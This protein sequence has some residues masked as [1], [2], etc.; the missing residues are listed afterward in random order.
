MPAGRPK[1]SKNNPGHSAGGKC[2]GSGPKKQ[3]T[4]GPSEK[5]LRKRKGGCDTV[6][7]VKSHAH[8]FI[9]RNDADNNDPSPSRRGVPPSSPRLEESGAAD[10]SS[11]GQTTVR[12]IEPPKIHSIFG[13]SNAIRVLFNTA[14]LIISPGNKRHTASDENTSSSAT[15][16]LP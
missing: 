9:E 7:M 10:I 15:P 5:S 13:M 6:C 8:A 11:H 2:R 12:P 16:N 4:E 1:G 14:G 3:P